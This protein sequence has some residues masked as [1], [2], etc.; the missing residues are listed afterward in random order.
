MVIRPDPTSVENAHMFLRAAFYRRIR[1]AMA[2]DAAR[3]L[4]STAMDERN[5]SGL[6]TPADV[7]REI[8]TIDPSEGVRF[9]KTL[10]SFRP[11][12]IVNEVETAQDI[13]FGFSLSKVCHQFFGI[14]PEYLGYVNRDARVRK[15]VIQ[16]SPI[17]VSYP[18]SDAAIYLN[19]IARKLAETVPNRL[20]IEEVIP[21]GSDDSEVK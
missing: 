6:K 12:I 5:E 21:A 13:K 19:R 7:L 20:V 16:K 15:S 10:Q 11:Q 9:E 3:G 2:T 17:V 8:E 1:Q 14:E 18:K 4:V